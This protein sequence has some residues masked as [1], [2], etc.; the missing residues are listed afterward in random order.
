MSRVPSLAL[1]LPKLTVEHVFLRRPQKLPGYAAKGRQR[2]RNVSQKTS[3]PWAGLRWMA[4]TVARFG[5]ACCK[6]QV[7]SLP[8][9]VARHSDVQDPTPLSYTEEVMT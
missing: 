6:L 1:K 9:T 4:V 7:D 2:T 3:P 5:A 8:S